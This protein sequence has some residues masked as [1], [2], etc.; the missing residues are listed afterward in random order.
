MSA[1]CP[2]FT[3]LVELDLSTD[4]AGGRRDA[5]QR[6]FAAEVARRGLVAE[7]GPSAGRWTYRITSESSQATDLDRRALESWAAARPEILAVR[8]GQLVE[9]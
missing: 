7:G 6:A 4:L 2:I 5:L 1:P 8:V 3:F 9:L